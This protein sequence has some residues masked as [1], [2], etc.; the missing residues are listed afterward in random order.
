MFIEMWIETYLGH[1]WKKITLTFYGNRCK[2]T[3]KVTRFVCYYFE[4]LENE[5]Y[6]PLSKGWL[7]FFAFYCIQYCVLLYPISKQDGTR[8]PGN[9]AYHFYGLC[10]QDLGI[11]D[12]P[13]HK[14]RISL[15]I[16][17]GKSVSLHSSNR[18]TEICL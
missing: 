2:G 16:L 5:R 11:L 13:M 1:I 10:S 4:G 7:M 9:K 15:K 12:S 6:S 14:C 17:S 3:C 8:N 18:L